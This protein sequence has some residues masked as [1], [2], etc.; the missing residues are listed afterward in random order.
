MRHFGI[1]SGLKKGNRAWNRFHAA[2]AAGDVY[3]YAVAHRLSTPLVR[4]TMH[5][6]DLGIIIVYLIA[7]V[8]IGFLVYSAILDARLGPERRS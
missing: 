1:G 2:I 5:A 8:V 4:K 3:V 7:V 6:I